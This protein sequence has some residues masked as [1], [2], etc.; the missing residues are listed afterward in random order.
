MESI[1]EFQ[2]QLKAIMHTIAK[3][4]GTNCEVVLH[5]HSK[6]LEHSVVEIENGYVTGRKVGDS[7][8]NLGF[9]IQQNNGV[10][11]DQYGYITKLPNGKT[12]RSSSVYFTNSEGKVLGSLCINLD[13]SELVKLNEYSKEMIESQSKDVVNE[14]FAGNVNDILDNLIHEYLNSS[15]KPVDEMNKQ[16]ICKML[17]FLNQKGAF[18]IRNSVPK[19]CALLKI[20]KFTLYAYLKEINGENKI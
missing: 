10:Y 5:N 15:S 6:G 9:E 12:L 19:V 2:P 11:Q 18:L 20:S 8:T 1:E 14:F 16:D 3:Q 13:I 17:D 7:S 4:F